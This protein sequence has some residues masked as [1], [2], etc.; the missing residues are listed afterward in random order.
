MLAP[1]IIGIKRKDVLG[2]FCS[3]PSVLFVFSLRVDSALQW[4]VEEI[5]Q[6]SRR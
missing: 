6:Y 1:G 4:S 5:Y 3:L 2:T